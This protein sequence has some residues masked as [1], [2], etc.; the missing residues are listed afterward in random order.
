MLP[1][2][3]GL[4]PSEIFVPLKALFWNND[5]YVHLPRRTRDIHRR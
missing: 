3:R 4:L 1:A 5:S 2:L